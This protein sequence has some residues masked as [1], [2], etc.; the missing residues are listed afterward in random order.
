[1]PVP[2]KPWVADYVLKGFF[3]ALGFTPMYLLIKF[4]VDLVCLWMAAK[5]LQIAFD[6]MPTPQ[7]QMPV[8]ITAPAPQRTPVA[9]VQ[10]ARRLSPDEQSERDCSVAM[11]KFSQSKLASD[12]EQMYQ[13]CK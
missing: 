6:S 9:V 2:E 5:G 11:L 3:F 7:I 4:L 13:V 8:S 1:M 12:K 10:D